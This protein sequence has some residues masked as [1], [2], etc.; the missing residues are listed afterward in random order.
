M[1]PVEQAIAQAQAQANQL[2]TQAQAQVPQTAVAVTANVGAFAAP[3]MAS[4][5]VSGF[6]VDQ[7]VKITDAGI[8]MKKDATAK[9][10]QDKIRVVID[11]TEGFGFILLWTANYGTPVRYI[12]SYDGVNTTK[13]ESF[14]TAIATA[15][16]VDPKVNPYQTVKISMKLLADAGG[17]TAG[18]NLGLS[19]TKTGLIPWQQFYQAVAKAGLLGQEVEVEVSYKVG[20]KQGFRDWGIPVFT[21]IGEHFE[22]GGE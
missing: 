5:M 20:K 8:L 16:A 9:E 4:L 19:L 1:N 12:E 3:S 18:T 17:V 10:A 13:G 7:F 15:Y 2:A 14:A 6:A 11:M 22:H 21:L